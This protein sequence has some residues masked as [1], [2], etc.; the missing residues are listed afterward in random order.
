[1]DAGP[2][3]AI[4]ETDLIREEK[5]EA[6]ADNAGN[7]ARYTPAAAKFLPVPA[8]GMAMAEVIS[9]MPTTVPMPNTSR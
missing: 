7:R 9:I 6:S 4:D 1:M 3:K 5:P 2:E 8:T